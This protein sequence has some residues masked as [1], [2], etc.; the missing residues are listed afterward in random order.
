MID[1]GHLV[2]VNKN[3]KLGLGMCYIFIYFKNEE[4]TKLIIT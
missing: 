2:H 1:I 3:V 4:H